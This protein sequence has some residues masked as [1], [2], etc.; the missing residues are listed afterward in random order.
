MQA[1]V[2]FADSGIHQ[3]RTS[4]VEELLAVMR[5][6]LVQHSLY[7][8]TRRV[9]WKLCFIASAFSECARYVGW[10]FFERSC[11]CVRIFQGFIKARFTIPTCLYAL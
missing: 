11:S 10:T 2:V 8:C 9:S 1:V 6:I 3:F 4:E 5:E 7:V